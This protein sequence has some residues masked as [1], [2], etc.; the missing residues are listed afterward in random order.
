[1][2]RPIIKEEELERIDSLAKDDGWAKHDEIDYNQKLQF[3]DDENLEDAP[4]TASRAK[5]AKDNVGDKKVKSTV[6]EIRYTTKEEPHPGGELNVFLILSPP[7]F[8]STY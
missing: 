2:Q 4:T 6:H 7:Q 8:I 3:S 1:M 5:L